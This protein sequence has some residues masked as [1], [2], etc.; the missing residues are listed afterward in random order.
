VYLVQ[1][2]LL[3]CAVY[4]GVRKISNNVTF[5]MPFRVTQG[6]WYR[7]NSVCLIW[8]FINR[9]YT[10]CCFTPVMRYE[11]DDQCDKIGPLL[12]TFCKSHWAV[13]KCFFKSDVQKSFGITFLGEVPLF[14]ERAR[15]LNNRMYKSMESSE[16]KWAE[17]VCFS[18][19]LARD[20]SRHTGTD[21]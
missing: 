20:R 12:T 9:T 11:L 6:Y 4:M 16:P 2:N 13:V 19:T 7:C 5:S 8:L 18:G 10:M 15:F 14:F 21:P 17:S 1:K 3:I